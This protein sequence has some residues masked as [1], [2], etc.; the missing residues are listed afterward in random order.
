[1]IGGNED[2]LFDRD[3]HVFLGRRG[4]VVRDGKESLDSA[5]AFLRV[6]IVDRPGQ[7]P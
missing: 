2:F 4:S 1:M 7:L 3:T 5:A 6:A